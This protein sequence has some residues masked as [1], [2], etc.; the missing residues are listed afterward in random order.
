MQGTSNFEIADVAGHHLAYSQRVG[1]GSTILLVHGITTY[2]FIWRN[3]IPRFPP[4]FN[5]IAL[6]LLGCGDSDKPLDVSYSLKQHA[7]RLKEFMDVLGID[8]CHLVGHDVGGGIAQVF[9][10]NNQDK[11]HSLTLLNSVGYDFWPVQPIIAMR[12]P[13]LRKLAMASLDLGTLK[14]IVKRG[15]YYKGKV[16][17]ELM[18]YFWYPMKT[19]EGR[20]A[21]LHFAKCL[22]NQDLLEIES[23]LTKLMVPTLIIRGDADVYLSGAIAQRLNEGMPGSKLVV[24]EMGGHF[25]QEDI[26]EEVAGIISEM[27]LN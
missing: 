7:I 2:R 5:V 18:E 20:K 11:L 8:K 6:D 4:D 17:D 27:F 19:V 24:L 10:V 15:L 1:T 16:T 13:I 3:M 26:P 12:T 23:A 25:I 21:F 9:A 14:L 22:D